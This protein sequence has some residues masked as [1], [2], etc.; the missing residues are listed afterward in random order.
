MAWYHLD[1]PDMGSVARAGII[2]TKS[3][4]SAP[5]PCKPESNKSVVGYIHK[6]IFNLGT[7]IYVSLGGFGFSALLCRW[8][9]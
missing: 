7:F 8:L 4:N 3:V 1:L 5:N 2:H 6:G 9:S